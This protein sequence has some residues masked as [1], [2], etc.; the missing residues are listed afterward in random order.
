MFMRKTTTI[1]RKLTV[2]LLGCVCLSSQHAIAEMYKWLDAEGNT[3]YTQSP[4]PGDIEKEVIKPPPKI[5]SELSDK[6][7]EN[8]KKKLTESRDNRLKSK[9]QKKDEQQDLEKQ[10]AD[11]EK[12]RARLASYQR[13]R[14]NVKDKDGNSVRAPEEQRQKEIAKSKDLIAKLCK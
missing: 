12:A 3:H 7:L 6:Q 10:R 14:V 2:L 5:N 13:P 9:Q 1:N 8:R 11:C 4:P